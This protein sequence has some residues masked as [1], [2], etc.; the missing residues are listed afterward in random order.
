MEGSTLKARTICNPASSGG[1]YDP[2]ELRREIEGYELEWITTQS[3]GD[4]REAAKAWRDR[5]L[6]VVGGDGTISEVVNGLG[7]AGFPP[8]R[9]PRHPRGSRRGRGR[10]TPESGADPGRGPGVRSEGVGEQFFKNVTTGGMG[11]EVSG[12]ADA[13]TKKRG[14]TDL[15]ACL[16]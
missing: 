8:G 13:E 2:T 12:A 4:A 5:L 7:R 15:S 10:L 14:E 9:D 16:T 6:I 1:G 3:P 11:A